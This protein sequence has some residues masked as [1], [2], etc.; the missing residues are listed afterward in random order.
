MM[1][2]GLFTSE[3][4]PQLMCSLERTHDS[5]PT[6]TIVSPTPAKWRVVPS[7]PESESS[8]VVRS[9]PESS[10]SFGVGVIRSRSELFWV[11]RSR[12]ESFGVDRNLSWSK[13]TGAFELVIRHFFRCVFF[14]LSLSACTSYTGHFFE[15]RPRPT[16]DDSGWRCL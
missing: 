11:V 13:S 3:Q 7:R 16:P 5:D 6:A 12:P 14:C 4:L 1:K 2:A 8:G 15:G 9:R 10:E